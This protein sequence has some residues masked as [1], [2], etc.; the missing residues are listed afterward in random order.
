MVIAYM[1]MAVGVSA[2]LAR[3]GMHARPTLRVLVPLIVMVGV[4]F[5]YAYEPIT[6]E[7]PTSPI[8]P[9]AGRVMEFRVGPGR[10]VYRQTLDQRTLVGGYIS[11][12]LPWIEKEYR[13]LPGVGW[14]YQDPARRR[15]TP[16]P[17]LVNRTLQQLDVEYVWVSP[18]SPE[19]QLLEQAGWNCAWSDAR[20]ALMRRQ[21]AAYPPM[22][23]SDRARP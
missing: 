1:S 16:D 14:F 6:C 5:D 19:Q 18:A 20:D 10:T 13:E 21:P 23:T 7:V 22:K 3:V 4:C 11:R 12:P 15:K 9:G 8:P 17:A 2:L